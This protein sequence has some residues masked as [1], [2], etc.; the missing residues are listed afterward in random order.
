MAKDLVI[1]ESPAKARTVQ[2]FLGNKYVAKASMGHVRDLPKTKMGIEIEE[3]SFKPTYRV[4]NDKRKV[5]TDLTKR[6]KSAGTVY[7]ATD[8]DREGE[9]ISWHLVEAAKIPMDKTKR[10]VFHEITR[11]A[12]QEAFDHPRELDYNLIDAQQGAPSAGQACGLP[13]EPGA[14]GEGEA[15]AVRRTSAVGR[16]SAGG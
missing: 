3:D 16:A 12:I 5:V 9:A 11:E 6:A 8:P 15:G 7:L 1:V 10:V 14:V 2:R 13:A 4:M